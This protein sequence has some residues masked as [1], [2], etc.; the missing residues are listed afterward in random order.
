MCDWWNFIIITFDICV[1]FMVVCIA[2]ALCMCVLKS[3]IASSAICDKWWKFIV[4]AGAI[5]RIWLKDCNECGHPLCVYDESSNYYWRHLCASDSSLAYITSA[6]CGERWKFCVSVHLLQL[7]SVYESWKLGCITGEISL[8]DRSLQADAICLWMERV[9][10]YFLCYLCIYFPERQLIIHPFHSLISLALFLENLINYLQN[11]T[12]LF[13]SLFSIE[14]YR[15]LFVEL[16][17]WFH[18]WFRVFLILN[19]KVINM[20]FVYNTLKIYSYI[21]KFSTQYLRAVHKL[22]RL[23]LMLYYSKYASRPT[24][25]GSIP[26]NKLYKVFLFTI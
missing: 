15:F 6:I 18:Q 22:I 25:Y 1:R 12:T 13:S 11:N 19:G 2:S 26:S 8:S 3:A 10:N 24:A 7:L 20:V 21:S 16:Q 4:T 9:C 23:L 17:F 14:I 5:C